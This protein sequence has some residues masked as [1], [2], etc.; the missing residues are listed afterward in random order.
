MSQNEKIAR[1]KK[2]NIQRIPPSQWKEYKKLR[3]Q[4]L[5][6]NP[7]AFS[8]PYNKEKTYSDKE[9]QQK[10]KDVGNGTD[11]IL[12]AKNSNDK[13]IGMIGGY[14]DNNGMK[15]H[16]AEIWGVYV[17]PKMRGKG[18]AKLL[19]AGILNEF[20]NDQDINSVVLGVNAD[21]ISAKKLYES[22]GFITK[23]IKVH[24]MG[25][26]KEHTLLNMQKSLEKH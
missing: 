9:W 5:K 18:V 26:G 13:L 15:N 6:N 3:L 22:F 4:A 24:L 7:Q 14:R 11:W 2:I 12:F 16:S 25:D 21:Q 19:I 10:L 17:D 23:R 1:L 20:K 8:S